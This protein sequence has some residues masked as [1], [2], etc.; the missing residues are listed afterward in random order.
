[1]RFSSY[2]VRNTHENFPKVLLFLIVLLLPVAKK[3][4]SH[5]AIIE[6]SHLPE[7]FLKN[8]NGISDRIIF[9]F[10]EIENTDYTGIFEL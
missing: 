4:W 7:Y 8:D 6:A 1:M 5:N 10:A 9:G 3:A 2:H